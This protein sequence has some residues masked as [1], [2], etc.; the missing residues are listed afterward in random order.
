MADIAKSGTP[1]LATL[2]PPP[3]NQRTLPAA[4]DIAAGD[5]VY[6]NS[7]GQFA[8]CNG[9]SANAAANWWGMAAR[10]AKSGRPVTAVHGVEF[11]YGASLTIAAR[12]YLSAATA[13]A[14]ADT[15]TTGGDVPTAFATGVDTIF[16][17]SPNR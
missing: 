7:S 5:M 17:I 1:S 14:L 12:Y 8:L 4:A 13:G 2:N 16:V 10:A 15:A 6:I 9:T 11:R 3:A